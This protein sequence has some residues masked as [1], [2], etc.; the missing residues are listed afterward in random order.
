MVEE[1]ITI[2]CLCDDYLKAIN[3][4]DNHQARISTSEIVTTAI[5]AAK[6]F[7]GNY[8]KSRMFLDGHNYIPNML[9][10]SRFIRRLNSMDINI[11]NEIFLIM[12]KAFK[13]ANVENIYAIDSFPVPVCANVRINRCKIY[14]ERHYKG[15]CASK[16]EFFY[17]IKVHMLVTKRGKP[18]EFVI[19]PGSKSDIKAAREFVFDIPKKSEIHADKAYVDYTFEDYLD[20]KRNISFN[21]KRKKNAKRPKKKFC[22]KTRK[23]I[24]T[25]F[26]SIVRN[27]SRKIHA[28]TA[29]G[30]ELKIVMFI[31][32]YAMGF[33]VAT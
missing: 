32:A 17:G 18:V 10:E 11:F 29:W 1:I 28:I 22:G 5:V 14:Q 8:Q 2:F 13:V 25:A 21:A 6:Y 23:I 12:A 26:S 4:K 24:E 20:L 31:F 7:G 3:Q 9:S 27:F 33:L 30:F 15:Y 16:Q 19:E